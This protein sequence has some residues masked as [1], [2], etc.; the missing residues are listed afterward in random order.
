MMTNFLLY[1]IY[2]IRKNSMFIR[3][4]FR[5]KRDEK[6]FIRLKFIF[7]ALSPTRFY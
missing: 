2:R 1:R 3:D 4:I 6:G 5:Q 7:R